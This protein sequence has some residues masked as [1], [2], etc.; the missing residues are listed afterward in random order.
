MRNNV[1][2][3]DVFQARLVKRLFVGRLTFL[4]N[5]DSIRI[6]LLKNNNIHGLCNFISRCP[7]LRFLIVDFRE[8]SL[9][10]KV[11]K[12]AIDNCPELSEIYMGRGVGVGWRSS[13]LTWEEYE[14]ELRT[15]FHVFISKYGVSVDAIDVYDP[16][17]D[18][19]SESEYYQLDVHEMRT[20]EQKNGMK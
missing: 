7:N 10:T 18:V 14:E 4:A 9:N 19:T 20:F 16:Y 11:I 5:I 6:L 2:A 1:S 3:A 13:G 8:V 17:G 12:T 15:N